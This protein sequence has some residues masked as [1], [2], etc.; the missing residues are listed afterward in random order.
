MG[1]GPKKSQIFTFV[2]FSWNF[3]LKMFLLFQNELWS[4]LK[5]SDEI[6]GTR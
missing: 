1:D 4:Y 2:K 6:P 3:E 5:K